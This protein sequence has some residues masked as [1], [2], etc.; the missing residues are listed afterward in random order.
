MRTG[1]NLVTGEQAASGNIGKLRKW[2]I[3]ISMVLIVLFL[4]LGGALGVYILILTG[5]INASRNRTVQIVNAIGDL[6]TTEQQYILV[7]DRISKVKPKLTD[8]SAGKNIEILSEISNSFPE[9]IKL[10]ESEIQPNSIKINFSTTSSLDL[11]ILLSIFTS[12]DKFDQVD[13]DDFSF[14]SQSGYIGTIKLISK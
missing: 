6:E 10:V 8:A 12:S 7:T 11:V 9:S 1:I 4:L 13:L 2:L 14:S 3:R 5:N